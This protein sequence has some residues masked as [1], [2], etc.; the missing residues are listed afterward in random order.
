MAES[1]HNEEHQ[2]KP[3]N[4]Y[5]HDAQFEVLFTTG[6]Y[7]ART[8]SLMLQHACDILLDGR[9]GPLTEE[10][11]SLIELLSEHGQ[12]LEKVWTELAKYIK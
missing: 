5:Y 4:K 11:R 2:L 7:E 1:S 10:Q 6:C 9:A 12:R 8:V 3:P